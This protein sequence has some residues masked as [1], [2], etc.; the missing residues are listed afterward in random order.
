MSR[1][2]WRSSLAGPR[3]RSAV[4][5]P[6]SRLLS[7]SSSLALAST[8]S[9]HAG[10]GR[11]ASSM[12]AGPITRLVASPTDADDGRLGSLWSCVPRPQPRRRN[13][14]TTTTSRQ[15]ID[16]P[17]SVTMRHAGL[18]GAGGD[19]AAPAVFWAATK[20]GRREPAARRRRR[21][22]PNKRRSKEIA[23]PQAIVLSSPVQVHPLL[24]GAGR[25]GSGSRGRKKPP[26]SQQ[27][28]WQC[29]TSAHPIGAP[30][31]HR[32]ARGDWQSVGWSASSSRP[33]ASQASPPRRRGPLTPHS[34]TPRTRSKERATPGIRS[35]IHPS[36]RS[37]CRRRW[38]W[39]TSCVSRDRITTW[40]A[41]RLL[42]RPASQQQQ[43]QQQQHARLAVDSEW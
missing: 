36:V 4:G 40:S 18:T 6:P 33:L 19:A 39:T 23:L 29:S 31:P 22:P 26:A 43:Q 17:D 28:E 24:S 34:G 8:R 2:A 7:C 12:H 1:R 27:R 42:G 30:T 21:A 32:G 15:R 37:P 9:T 11:S 10:G 16:A 35:S 38:P 25:W 5:A 14:E 3:A 13:N 20:K 41:S